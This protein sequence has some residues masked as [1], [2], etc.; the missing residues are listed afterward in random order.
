MISDPGFSQVVAV[1]RRQRWKTRDSS[2]GPRGKRLTRDAS[3]PRFAHPTS[4]RGWTSM[5]SHR[6]LIMREKMAYCLSVEPSVLILRSPF[7]LLSADL[8]SYVFSQT[9][10]FTSAMRAHNRIP[11][12]VACRERLTRSP[13]T[14]LHHTRKSPGRA[15][16]PKLERIVPSSRPPCTAHGKRIPRSSREQLIFPKLE[17]HLPT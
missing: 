11:A 8:D 7:P 2:R 10:Q 6:A 13:R 12:A 5:G 4:G 3:T 17:Q 14:R 9:Q 1:I 15:A 16:D